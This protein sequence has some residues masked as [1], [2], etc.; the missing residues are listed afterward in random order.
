MGRIRRRAG[1]VIRF[2]DTV[3]QAPV[4][5]SSLYIQVKQKS[6]VIWKEDGYVV[7]ME[8]PG[9][10]S[11]EVAVSGASFAPARFCMDVLRDAPVRVCYA[12]LLP[13]A[14]YPFTREMAVIRGTCPLEG[15]YAARL[16]GGYRLME[17]LAAGGDRVRV[18]GNEP[19]SPGQMLL[20]DDGERYEPVI[21][22]GIDESVGY[23]Y[24]LLDRLK[25][26]WKK[27]KTKVYSAIRIFPD[28]TGS[29]CVA[30]DRIAKG[31][32]KIR[33]IGGSCILSDEGTAQASVAEPVRG[34]EMSQEAGAGSVQEEEEMSQETEAEPVREAEGE[35]GQ[36]AETGAARKEKTESARIAGTAVYTEVEI[37]EGQEI[38]IHVGG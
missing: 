3:T 1:A 14:G 17:D 2:I 8:Q 27:G 7:I 10:D 4:S 20:L 28:D 25:G 24:Q 12:P 23:G 29:F 5:G 19:F 13:S 9:V 6:P 35:G 32:E 37:Q 16:A 15:M 22:I 34:E 18:W 30:Y 21:L 38:G 11:L 26:N 31:G 33:F 36:A